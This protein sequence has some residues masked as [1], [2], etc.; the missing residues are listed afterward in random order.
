MKKHLKIIGGF[1]LL[2]LGLIG[3][4]LPFVPGLLLLTA[5]AIC[6]APS[7]PGIQR[8]LERLKLWRP[9]L[10]LPLCQGEKYRR[11]KD[12]SKEEI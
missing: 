7:Y 3:L 5:G 6:L 10:F 1:V 8:L 2:L 12:Q 4:A 11:A 9:P